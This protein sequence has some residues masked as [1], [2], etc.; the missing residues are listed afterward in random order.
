MAT[1]RAHADL[2]SS[3][4]NAHRG[5]R[6]TI[7]LVAKGG[8]YT[9]TRRVCHSATPPHF[10]ALVIQ[11]ARLASGGSMICRAFLRSGMIAVLP[12]PVDE[13]CEL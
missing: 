13:G 6:L 7:D 8:A 9:T 1:E 10:G 12:E 4:Q 11:L 5:H 3:R 2:G